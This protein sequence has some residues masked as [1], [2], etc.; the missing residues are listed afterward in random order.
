[1]TGNIYLLPTYLDIEQLGTIPEATKQKTISL[2]YLIVENIRTT[3][4]YLKSIDRSVDIDSIKFFE[5]DKRNPK[6]DV[7][8]FIQPALKGHDIGIISEAGCPGIADP[9]Q[10][11]VDAAHKKGLRI[12]PLSGPSSIFMALMAS[13]MNGQEFRFHGYLPVDD[14]KRRKLIRHMERE[15]G[16]R[17][18]TQIFMETP[19]RNNP[20]IKTLVKVL[21]PKTRICFA[22]NISSEN[23]YIVTKTVADWK[24]E[25]PDLHKQPCIFLLQ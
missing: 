6:K 13:G 21:D 24:K 12:I 22:A 1:M 5:W 8:T 25:L 17:K 16:H 9:G 15:A 3:R 4:R 19:Y 23:E 7:H 11:V 20:L 2:K 14:L 18:E 10:L